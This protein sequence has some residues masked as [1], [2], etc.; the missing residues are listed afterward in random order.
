MKQTTVWII[1]GTTEGRELACYVSRF[2]VQ[3]YVSVATE[4]GAAFIPNCPNVTVLQQ[5]M[6]AAEMIRF[7]RKCEPVL[8]VDATH[9]YAAA[10]TEN[11]KTACKESGVSYLR[12]VRPESYCGGCISVW[13]MEEAVELLSHTDGTVFLTTGSKDLP[14]FTRLDGYA[15]RIVLRILPSR[16]SL[17][18]ALA[19][20]YR[21]AH[22][23]CMQ[24][25]FGEALNEAMFR[26]FHTAY[27]VTKDSGRPGGFEDKASGAARA[28]AELIVVRRRHEEGT[29]YYDVLEVIRKRLENRILKGK[30][31]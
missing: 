13:S 7:L 9:P 25:P 23:V 20:G 5:R 16:T 18:R 15:D 26:H 2:D 14:I 27:V 30:H 29:G 24:G 3:V 10:V 21:P 12:V 11:V 28:G 6:T 19:L 8:V 1:A 17:D 4:Y 22:I 31:L